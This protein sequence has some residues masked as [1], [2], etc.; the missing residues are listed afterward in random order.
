MQLTQENT[1]HH[2]ICQVISGFI[3]GRNSRQRR[4]R[5]LPSR[6]IGISADVMVSGLSD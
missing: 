4:L 3:E 5:H 6:R 2:E 1:D